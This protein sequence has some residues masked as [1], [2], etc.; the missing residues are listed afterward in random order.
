MTSVGLTFDAAKGNVRPRVVIAFYPERLLAYAGVKTE[1]RDFAGALQDE[2]K[3]SAFLR[4]LIDQ[5]GLRGQL[6]SGNL[7]GR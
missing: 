5:R 7:L 2:Q 1:A 6:Q 3:R 4:R